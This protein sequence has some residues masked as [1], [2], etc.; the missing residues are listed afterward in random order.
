M[1]EFKVWLE[2]GTPGQGTGRYPRFGTVDEDIAA[3]KG[4]RAALE[5][6]LNQIEICNSDS[7]II[8]WIK[9]ELQD[10]N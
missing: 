4:W 7:S 3:E 5:E 2:R 8:V 6:V 1:K 9:G 10:E